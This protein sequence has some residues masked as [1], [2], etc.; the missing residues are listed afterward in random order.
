MGRTSTDHPFYALGRRIT[1]LPVIH[2]SADY[3]LHVRRVLFDGAYDCVAVALPP[4]F[5]EALL[6][7]LSEVVERHVCALVSRGRLPVPAIDPLRVAHPVAADLIQRF[8]GQGIR[9]HLFD[10]SLDTGIPTVAALAWDPATFPERSEIV[11]TAGTTPDPAKALIRALTEVA[12]LA[13]DFET[14]ANYVASGLPKPAAL[15]EVDY[16]LQAPR[17]VS[18]ADLPDLSSPDMLQ[19]VRNCLAALERCGLQVMAVDVTHPQLEIPAL[20]TIVPG[21]HFRERASGGNAP[22]FA[23]K[24]ASELLPAQ[25]LLHWIDAMRDVV[26][27][28]YFLEFYEGRARMEGGDLEGALACFQRC[29]ERDVPAE[30]LPY[31]HSYQGACLRDLGRY[32]EAV[33]V[34]ESGRRFDDDRPDFHNMLGVCHFK[35]GR[36]E[37]AERHFQRAVDLN[38]SS[39]LD[40]A[41]LGMSR[42]RQDK[43]AA[44]A[45][46]FQEA[47]AIDDTI[48]FAVAGLAEALAA[49]EPGEQ[50]G[51]G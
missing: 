47:L 28:A 10:F 29:L 46:A 5:E 17:T 11:Y 24:L 16:L 39:A 6:Q 49:L 45:Q 31:V 21:A 37:E 48:E 22:L 40:H 50:D 19:E 2:E 18:L 14:R 23:A 34:L 7:G 20:Y 43:A 33:T 32:E 27:G 4:A 51:R 15:D 35:L 42:L 30:D 41:N 36:Y 25:E 9:L 1:L 8:T 26:P 13:G 3:A 38:P 12:Q 44:A